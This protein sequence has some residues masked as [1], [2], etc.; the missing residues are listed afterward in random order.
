VFLRNLVTVKGRHFR[1]PLF[2]EIDQDELHETKARL[3]P[4]AVGQEA[5]PHEAQDH[6]ARDDG[7]RTI[8]ANSQPPLPDRLVDGRLAE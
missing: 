1:R 6:H 3:A 2:A 5:H 4:A 8:L 7:P